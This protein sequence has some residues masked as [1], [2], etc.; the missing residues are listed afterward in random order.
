[1]SMHRQGKSRFVYTTS[2]PVGWYRTEL[3]RVAT[4]QFPEGT[5]VMVG[6]RLTYKLHFTSIATLETHCICSRL[7]TT[8][9]SGT[10]R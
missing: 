1:M 3:L 8:S 4:V 2:L 9:C 6:P 10:K 5:F 7:I